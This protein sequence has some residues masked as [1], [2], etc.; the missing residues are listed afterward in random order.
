VS[1]VQPRGEQVDSGECDKQKERGEKNNYCNQNKKSHCKPKPA[2]PKAPLGKLKQ[3]KQGKQ[4][5][6]VSWSR[7]LCRCAG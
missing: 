5:S 2:P 1:S 7:R 6:R 3:G 4:A